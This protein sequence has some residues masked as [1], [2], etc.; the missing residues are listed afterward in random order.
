MSTLMRGEDTQV[1][2]KH[3]TEYILCVACAEHHSHLYI[4]FLHS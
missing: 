1:I 4:Y 2:E 3:N